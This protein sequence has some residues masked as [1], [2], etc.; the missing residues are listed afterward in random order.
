MYYGTTALQPADAANVVQ[1]TPRQLLIKAARAELRSRTPDDVTMQNVADRAGLSR[2]TLYNQFAD[3]NCLFHAV[4]DD[5]IARIDSSVELKLAAD[6]A[7]DMLALD[8]VLLRFS[9]FMLKSLENKAHTELLAI[10]AARQIDDADAIYRDRVRNPLSVKLERRLLR[11]AQRGVPIVSNVADT[12]DRIYDLVSV[13]ALADG[14]QSSR[15][16]SAEELAEMFVKRLLTVPARKVVPI[17]LPR[18]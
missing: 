15:L 12:I 6:V 17:A 13:L 9:T 1:K 4:I 3:R 7:D 10:L 2:R 5:L 18:N 8:D 16:I 11:L 14:T